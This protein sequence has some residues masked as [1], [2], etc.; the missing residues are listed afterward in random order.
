M[1]LS[2]LRRAS[3]GSG[4]LSVRSVLVG[5]VVLLAPVTLCAQRCRFRYYSHRDG[6]QVPEVHA[7][8]QDRT[9]FLWT[10]T[11][12]GLF[13]YDGARFTQ[14]GGKAGPPRPVDALGQTP[15]GTL[16]VG[17][18]NGLARLSGGHLEFVDPPGRV[19]VN[20]R[21]GIATDQRGGIYVA[22]SNGL[23]AG[24]AGSAGFIFR[25]YPN[26]AQ[27]ADPAAYG[28]YAGPAGVVWFGCGR[29]LFLLT[30]ACRRMVT[31]P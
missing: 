19:V 12:G 11:S 29:T 6:L 25:H 22:T 18:P 9:G 8:L 7:L 13:R 24:H 26:P 30:M 31:C 28:V 4:W 27:V 14:F 16:W 15:D 3:L 17:T 1:L 21:S 5:V 10:G 23:Y 20:G 2:R